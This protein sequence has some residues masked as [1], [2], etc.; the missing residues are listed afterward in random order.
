[1]SRFCS[2][3]LLFLSTENFLS[4]TLLCFRKFLVCKKF[5]DKK[6]GV[7]FYRRNFF[8]SRR[9][10]ASWANPSVFEEVSAREIIM[11][12][13]GASRF[14]VGKFLSHVAEK[15]RGR[16]ILCFGIVLVLKIFCVLGVTPF[17]QSFLSHSTKKFHWGTLVI[18]KCSGIKR[19]LDN[20]GITI[21]SNF[22]VSHRQKSSWPNRSVFW[23]YSG[24]KFFLDNEV[25]RFCG[26]LLSHDAEL[27]WGNLQWFIKI[28]AS[29]IFLLN[30]GVSRFS[31]ADF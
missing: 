19:F 21:S 2:E 7:S 15:Q 25:S 16:T 22:F 24:I 20:R 11:V 1:M 29:E 9:R 4:G 10:K 30:G 14:S 26:T 12:K 31:V 23:N 6:V 18:Q 13:K 5:R 27:L 3:N 28:R 8:V 17:C